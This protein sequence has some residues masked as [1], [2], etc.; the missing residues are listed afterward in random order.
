VTPKEGGHIRPKKGNFVQRGDCAL[1]AAEEK[2]PGKSV[3]PQG[4]GPI[5]TAR[6]VTAVANRV[7]KNLDAKNQIRAGHVS[8]FH[9]NVLGE[10]SNVREG[11]EVRGGGGERK[12]R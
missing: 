10:E 8:C 1:C 7:S 9:E 3:W 6:K 11:E 2:L 12:G 5:G 4:R